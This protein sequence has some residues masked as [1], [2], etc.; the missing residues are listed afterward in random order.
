MS[1]TA[2]LSER[3]FDTT[4]KVIVFT[5]Q[6]T[7]VFPVSQV[8]LSALSF[9]NNKKEIKQCTAKKDK[10]EH[11]PTQDQLFKGAWRSSLL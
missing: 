2:R 9:M 5:P 6:Q 11:V 1:T 7:L 10:N 3:S 4:L 8:L